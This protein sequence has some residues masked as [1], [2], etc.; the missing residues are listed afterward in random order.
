[1]F[2]KDL[3]CSHVKTRARL[4]K[5]L[6]NKILDLAKLKSFADDRLIFAKM[7]ICLFHKVENIV[8]KGE[9]AGY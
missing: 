7:M 9:N 6:P 4:G 5:G 2:S 8:G 3:Y 1:M